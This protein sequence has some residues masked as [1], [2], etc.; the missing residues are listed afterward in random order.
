MGELL[1]TAEK[2]RLD[3]LKRNAAITP[4]NGLGNHRTIRIGSMKRH[5]AREFSLASS[6]LRPRPY[7]RRSA[8]RNR[9]PQIFVRASAAR[10]HGTG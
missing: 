2:P 3:G 6:G 10:I 9:T 4:I 8:S 7:Q 1:H 5:A